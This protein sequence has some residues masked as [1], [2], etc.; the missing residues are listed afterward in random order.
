[1]NKSI[2]VIGGGI[3]G[4]CTAL[5]LQRTGNNV[6][7]IDRK[8]PGRE[9]SY[10]NAGVLSESSVM[11]INNPSLL[12]SLPKYLLNNK[13][14]LRYNFFFVLRN[15]P[16]MIRFLSFC[17][18]RHMNHA[19]EALRSILLISLAKHK[20]WIKASKMDYLLKSEGGWLKLFRSKKTYKKYQLELALM[21]KLNVKFTVFEKE[22]IRQI[23][24]GL[25][26]IYEKAVLM[27][28]TCRISNPAALTD[29]YVQ[30]FLDSGGTVIKDDVQS[31][32]QPETV[33]KVK[34]AKSQ[35]AAD[36]VVLAAGGWSEEIAKWVGYNVPLFW[37][38]GYHIHLQ[39]SE[40]PILNRTVNDIDGGFIM[41]PMEQGV[42]ITS[43]VEVTSRD[44]EPNYSQIRES[45]KR[46]RDVYK[47]GD[48]IEEVP[49]M[50]RR[51]TLIDSLPIVGAAPKHN[52]LW[53]N[54][55]HQHLGLSMAP[56][57]AELITSFINGTPPPI[58]PEPFSG[59]RFIM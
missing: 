46:A 39:P 1:M 43:G 25:S 49:W 10:G 38:R 8:E 27:D 40:A 29:A 53:F 36:H 32:E 55:G 33:W 9:T 41:A 18:T 57:S 28:E 52:G 56:G 12:K 34:T 48:E 47:M 15:L 16:K 14:D 42:R 58:D 44:A 20:K 50:G 11:V 23:E 4:V 7:L 31:L 19:G 26:P 17:T 54:F 22:K 3:V 37:E 45:V 51:P 30:M 21:K 6:T 24:P 35:F 2:I 5:E 13:N 59:K